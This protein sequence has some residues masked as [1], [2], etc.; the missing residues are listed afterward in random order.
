MRAHFDMRLI[1]QLIA[2]ESDEDDML[3]YYV[4]T[5][6]ENKPTRQWSSFSDHEFPELSI[7]MRFPFSLSASLSRVSF[8][9]LA[10][11]L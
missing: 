6:E 4:S 3:I 5:A 7:R 2:D 1:E 10:S 8:L 11:S 9:R